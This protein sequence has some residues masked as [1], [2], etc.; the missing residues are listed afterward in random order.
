[1]PWN[2]AADWHRPLKSLLGAPQR[3]AGYR[4]FYDFDWL[5]KFGHN[6]RQFRNCESVRDQVRRWNPGG[7]RPVILLTDDPAHTIPGV[8][9]ED[10]QEIV[11]LFNI[12]RVLAATPD[13]VATLVGRDA[14]PQLLAAAERIRAAPELM[15]QLVQEE[16]TAEQILEWANAGPDQ[17]T[18]V[19]RIAAA[20]ENVDRDVLAG[21]GLRILGLVAANIAALDQFVAA[22]RD[23]AVELAASAAAYVRRWCPEG[24]GLSPQRVLPLVDA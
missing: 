15:R 10:D 21:S 4:V 13:V 18:A 16:L 3:L 19:V 14:D 12:D 11:C 2:P 6:G 8:H 23:A 20:L 5:Q 1:M 17:A 7:K 24:C 9:R 22:N